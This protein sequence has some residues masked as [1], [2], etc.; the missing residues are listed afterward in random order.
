MPEFTHR[1][2]VDAAMSWE[3]HKQ[4]LNWALTDAAER[5]ARA[6]YGS[7]F[8]DLEVDT[9]ITSEDGDFIVTFAWRDGDL[10]TTRRVRVNFDIITRRSGTAELDIPMG[11]NVEQLLEDHLN[12]H[13]T[14]LAADSLPEGTTVHQWDVQEPGD[15]TIEADWVE[16][17]RPAAENA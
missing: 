10:P 13:G 14:A 11:A 7:A 2:P 3:L 6:K 4:T 5:A 15:H 1:V 9:R 12:K 16:D 8:D 17:A